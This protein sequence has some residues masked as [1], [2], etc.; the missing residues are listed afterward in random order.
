MAVAVI[1][2]FSKGALHYDRQAVVQGICARSLG[3]YLAGH[4]LPSGPILEI[5][6]GTGF[7][8][9][10]IIR[11]FPNAPLYIT[12]ICPAMLE[13]CRSN[14]KACAHF[15]LLDGEAFDETGKYAAIIS[16]LTF[17]WF[18]NFKTSVQTLYRGLMPGGL[19]LF[20]FVE[21]KS[22]PEWR[23]ICTDLQLP[24]T[25]N[26]FPALNEVPFPMHSWEESIPLVYPDAL[27]CLMGFKRIGANTS[28]K[29]RRLTASQMLRLLRYWDE[30]PQVTLTYNIAT[31][32]ITCTL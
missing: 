2:N 28:L 29:N 30:Q 24:C 17:Q 14:I 31:V 19:L 10:E 5:G 15:G 21:A 6:C 25:A 9:K 32:A 13:K 4:S 27:T 20:S 26:D 8:T 18:R 12:D 1:H 22:F 16:G 7:V 23:K 11:S 3:K